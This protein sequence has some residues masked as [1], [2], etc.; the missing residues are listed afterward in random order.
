M[1]NVAV[2]LKE[3]TFDLTFRTLP[4]PVFTRRL[5]KAGFAIEAGSRRLPG[6]PWDE[7]AD[8]WIMLARRL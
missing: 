3:H 1:S 8:V 5:E 4:I 2:R 7:R 6:G